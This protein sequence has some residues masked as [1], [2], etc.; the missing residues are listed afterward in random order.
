[1]TEEE[2]NP[3]PAP[4][5]RPDP[6]KG[7]R[8]VCS[9]ILILEM[10][11]VL[12]G[13]PVVVNLS[14]FHGPGWAPTAFVLCFAALLFWA[15]AVQSKPWGFSLDLGLQAVLVAGWLVHPAIGVTGLIFAAVWAVVWWMRRAVQRAQGAG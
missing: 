15:C 9:G 3:D 10:I 5:E 14:S 13:V 6:W 8:G 12:L 2:P 4:A 11:A 7:F 1:M